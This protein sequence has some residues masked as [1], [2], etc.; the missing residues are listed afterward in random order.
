VRLVSTPQE[1]PAGP[2]P[3]PEGPEVPQSSLSPAP[4]LA[5]PDPVG[6]PSPDHP[7]RF[8]MSYP[9]ELNRW[10][11]LVKWL[12]I[13]PHFFALFFVGIGAFFVGIYAFFAV[14]I[15]GRWPRGAFDY[16]VGTF[17]WVYRVIAYFHLM[18]DA[19]PPFSLADDPG[20]PV[21]LDIAYP[22][23][24]DR[25]RPLVQWLLAIPYLI[26]ASILYWLT[27]ILSFVAFF[28][29]LFTKRIP[30]EMFELMLPGLRWNLRGNAYA[31]FL[32]DRYPPFV[33]G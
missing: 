30:R 12:L 17:R 8:E 6:P 3:F 4:A 1:P 7:A 14:L 20:Y 13:I 18:T 29:I 5:V 15:T 32:T 27:G 22:E 11:P 9:D 26:I 25:W 19:Y 28:T 33:F 31:Y 23:H 2:P 24:V 21:R 16:L 10:L